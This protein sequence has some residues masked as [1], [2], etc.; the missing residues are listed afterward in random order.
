MIRVKLRKTLVF[1]L[2]LIFL[3][4]QPVMA[5]ESSGQIGSTTTEQGQSIQVP[6]MDPYVESIDGIEH[7]NKKKKE[8]TQRNIQAPENTVTKSSVMTG[9]IKIK[10]LN[11]IRQMEA[12]KNNLIHAKEV[13]DAI[14]RLY[15]KLESISRK[16]AFP[17]EILLTG[18]E[19]KNTTSIDY[20]V[21]RELFK[22]AILKDDYLNSVLKKYTFGFQSGLSGINAMKEDQVIHLK[23]YLDRQF[24]ETGRGLK[25]REQTIQQLNQKIE[26]KKR[27]IRNL[28][29]GE[30]R[31][32]CPTNLL[33]PSNLS[34]EEIEWMLKG[35]A[36][37]QL[38]PAFYKCED[39]YGVNAVAIM[40][41]AIHESAWG[42]SRRARED[43]NLTGYGVTSDSA[44]GINAQTKEQNLLMTAKLLKEKY[45]IPGSVYYHEN[46]SL[47]GVNYHYCVGDE[48]AA[49]VTNYGY[50][51]MDKLE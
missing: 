45:L 8:E 27:D 30:D 49:A 16:E 34:V 37:E 15:Q 7:K 40:G 22:V 23:P 14:S 50:K 9:K 48:W 20:N 19:K 39:V 28:K 46:P 5:A 10:L 1:V 12:E 36:L 31:V 26:K 47:V 4:N 24:F 11:D 42:T 3:V 35:T 44:K 6:D 13:H 21:N 17:L 18:V 25:Q 29:E 33:E 32:F 51:L 2:G 38:A 43:N 41:I